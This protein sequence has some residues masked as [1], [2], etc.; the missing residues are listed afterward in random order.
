MNK[1]K[2]MAPFEKSAL[3]TAIWLGLAAIAPSAQ[4]VVLNADATATVGGSTISETDVGSTAVSASAFAGGTV[5]VAS[6]AGRGND[7]GRTYSRAGGSGIFSAQGRI[8][9]SMTFTNTSGVTQ[10]YFFDFTINRGSLSAYDSAGLSGDFV[11]AGNDVAI[12]LDGDT[13]FTSSA[14]LLNDDNGVNLSM[15]GTILGSYAPGSEYYAWGPYTGTLSLGAFDAGQVFTLEY[16]ILTFSS[17]D[18]LW[19]NCGD[20]GYGSDGYGNVSEVGG[21]GCRTSSG[22][23]QFGDPNSVSS[24]PIFSPTNVIGVPTTSVPEPGT[25]F[26]MGGG[27]L[28]LAF[29]RRRKQRKH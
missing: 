9:Q 12:T 23:S 3:S 16:D 10:N 17:S 25:L 19:Q 22:K 4:A 2:K 20:D 29:A 8:Q 26:L 13:L 11:L 18:T 7:S 5:G 21:G 15:A 14:S 27:V 24:S 28:G 1:I 6:S